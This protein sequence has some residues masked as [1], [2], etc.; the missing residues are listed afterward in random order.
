MKIRGM[1]LEN[2]QLIIENNFTKEKFI[3]KYLKFFSDVFLMNHIQESE[4]CKEIIKT[5][6][7]VIGTVYPEINLNHKTLAAPIRRSGL[8]LSLRF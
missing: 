3:E 5:D 1:N 6:I 8:E 7:S 4:T 2:S